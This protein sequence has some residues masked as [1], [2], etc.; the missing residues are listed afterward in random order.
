M[1]VNNVD[2]RISVD[3]VVAGP[4]DEL[5]GSAPL[6]TPA[7]GLVLVPNVVFELVSKSGRTYGRA[8]R[9]H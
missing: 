4:L 7:G 2:D 9:F 6:R 5:A 1:R 3:S 8:A